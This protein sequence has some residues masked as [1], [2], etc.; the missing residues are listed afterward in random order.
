MSVES[1]PDGTVARNKAVIRRWVDVTN[2]HDLAALTELFTSDTFDNVGGVAGPQWWREVF[3]FLYATLPDWQWTL[4]D[5]VAEGDRVVARLTVRGTHRGSEIP[6]LR[7]I[8][9]TGRAVTWTHHHSFRLVDGRIAEH[10]AN[11]DDLGLLRQ[12][13][14]P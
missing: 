12:V 5:L 13:T 14:T 1:G 7:G 11:R 9:P 6:F 3:E 10:W 8:A 4:D 2:A